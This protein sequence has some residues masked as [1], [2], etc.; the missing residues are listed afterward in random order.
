[1]PRL[2]ISLAEVPLTHPP[3]G[4]DLVVRKADE[5]T[6]GVNHLLPDGFQVERAELARGRVSVQVHERD[7]GVFVV[8]EFPGRGAVNQPVIDLTV[9]PES[10]ADF[11][12]GQ[13]WT[14]ACYRLG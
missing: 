14:A 13:V 8:V 3:L 1:M 12:D 4:R 9:L 7:L 10:Q 6:A 11:T 5:V 2:A